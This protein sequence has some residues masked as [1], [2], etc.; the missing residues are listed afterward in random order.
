MV[1]PVIL[2]PPL[3]EIHDMASWQKKREMCGE[4]GWG[5]CPDPPGDRIKHKN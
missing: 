3:L 1:E 2:S 4:P 5:G